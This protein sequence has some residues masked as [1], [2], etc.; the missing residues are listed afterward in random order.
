MTSLQE[1]AGTRRRVR[2]ERSRPS[3]PRLNGYVLDAANGL[4]LVHPFDDFEPNGYAIIRERD[5]VS[6]RQGDYEAFWD[7]MLEA[8]GLLGGLDEAP[9]IDLS[10]MAMAIGDAAARYPFLAIQCE[11][12]DEAIQDFYFAKVR[13]VTD[14]RVDV[15]CVDGLGRWEEPGPFP[16]ED[17]TLVEM[18]TPYLTRFARYVE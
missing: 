18:G 17:V 12:E 15:R 9:K 2:I 1:H 8:E 6:V 16:L 5:V 10:S 14:S 7:R 4:A 3:N 13:Y 11:D